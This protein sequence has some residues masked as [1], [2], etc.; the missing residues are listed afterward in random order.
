MSGLA[1]QLIAENKRTRDHFL[2]LGSCGIT[3]VPAEV[4]ELVWLQSLS[5]AGEKVRD[6]A[7]LARLRALQTLNI[8]NTQ[9]SDLFALISLI[10]RGCPVR[11]SSK[12]LNPGIY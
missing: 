7:P 2:N 11:W 1:Q 5:L 4:G 10:A 12:W 9:V 3:E 8:C 6:L